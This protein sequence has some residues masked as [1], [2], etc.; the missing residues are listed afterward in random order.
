[1]KR[2]IAFLIGICM[3]ALISCVFCAC[4]L[5]FSKGVKKVALTS[6][7]IRCSL[8]DETTRFVYTGKPIELGQNYITVI[9]DGEFVSNEYFD[10][11]YENNVNVGVGTLRVTA[12]ENNPYAK[13]SAEIHFTI[14][15]DG[16]RNCDAE[17]DL[18]A[19]LA[20]PGITGVNLWCDKVVAEGETLTV[21]E[22]KTLSMLYGY[23]FRNEG[24][25]VNYGTIVIRGASLSTGGRR[26]SE[27]VNNGTFTNHGTLTLKD[28]AVVE[29]NGI[30][31]SDTE[32]VNLGTVYLKD[33]D[34]T[35][36]TDGQSGVHHVRTPVTADVFSVAECVYTQGYS[37]YTPRVT[38]LTYGTDFTV[39]Y[40]D[41]HHAG[42]A[43]AT[44]TMGAR[45]AR[46][47][48]SVDLPFV[49]KRGQAT[50][51]SLAQMKELVES[52]DYIRYTISALNIPEG[53]TFTLPAGETM[54]VTNGIELGGRMNALGDVTCSALTVAE[55]ATFVNGG[56]LS[57]SGNTFVVSG[58]FENASGG[59]WTFPSKSVEVSGT[60]INRGAATDKNFNI[61]GGTLRNE[62]TLGLSFASYYTGVFENVGNATFL[63]ANAYSP[64]FRNGQGGVVTLSGDVR[65]N[66]EF[67]NAGAVVNTGRVLLQKNCAYAC[68]GTF[69]NAEGDVWAY[70]DHLAGV[71]ENYHPKKELSDESVVFATQY[72]ETPYNTKDQKPTFTVDGEPLP[73]GE[74]SCTYYYVALGKYQTECIRTGEIRM[75]VS[76]KT[77]YS[78]YAGYIE[79]TYRII[80]A[81]VRVKD[82]SAFYTAAKDDGYNEI[83][84]DADIEL[85]LSSS[86]LSG[87]TLDLNEHRLKLRDYF[88]IHGTLTGGAAVDPDAFTPSAE[89]AAVIVEKDGKL[90]NY[91]S[92]VNDGFLYVAYGGSFSANAQSTSSGSRGTVVNNGVIYSPSD[93]TVASGAGK[94]YRRRDLSDLKNLLKVPTVAYDG[95]EKTPLPTMKYNGEDVDMERFTY[96]YDLNLCAGTALV[97]LDVED[98]FDPDFIGWAS[99]PF[100]IERGTI[101]VLN[102]SELAAAA[103][104]PNYETIRLGKNVEVESTIPFSDDQ[105]FDIGAYEATGA[106]KVVL[107][108]NCKLIL[109]TDSE[110]RFVKY[111]Y[112]A[113]EITLTG[114]IGVAGTRT[115][116]DFKG[117]TLGNYQNANYLSTTVHLD[118]YS[119]IG[120]LSIVNGSIENFACEFENA[121][122]TVS[123]I[124]SSVTGNANG[125]ALVYGTCYEE[126]YVTLRNITVYGVSH[127]GGGGT[128]QVVDLSAEKCTFLAARDRQNA[129]AFRVSAPMSGSGTYTECTFDG[130]NAYYVNR[131]DKYDHENSRYLPAYFFNDC[132][133][134]SYAEYDKKNYYGNAIT[135]NYSGNFG[136]GVQITNSQL[137]SEN[138]YGI[139]V[140]NRNNAVLLVLDNA[141]TYDGPLSKV[142]G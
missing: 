59:D 124:G 32:I 43:V 98:P 1:M 46:Y 5:I 6:E 56:D 122:E 9:V 45:D 66:T 16:S 84:L 41:N 142:F 51:T 80:P 133:L 29:D 48:G 57:V 15:A 63:G 131:G 78:S 139:Q 123:T 38:A 25:L 53:D 42:D 68:S 140:V 82:S 54:I 75:R 132:T 89:T 58:T 72:Y 108:K 11:T 141:T 26:A 104:D 73:T 52:G 81:S 60:F 44:V 62:G 13:G 19:L 12:K 85:W 87:C 115:D 2:R 24:T 91:G 125:Y 20:D 3:L 69:D 77:D 49:I 114:D 127:G 17:D 79:H 7:M 30:F 135:M 90:Y 105:L 37:E 111:F 116:L 14:V 113:D 8:I 128:S 100:T 61:R 47:Y 65:F 107:G 121:S 129:Y 36:L 64:A 110:A 27:L 130:A 21:P 10:F 95:T 18:A 96:R 138:G 120:G 101:T 86:V 35:F 88:F 39:G 97:R 23:R 136:L 22:G 106:G 28:Y 134:H 4:S 76:I 55:G 99:L 31:T 74:Y 119:F 94:V 92:I 40:T 103:A 117:Y 109:T 33:N 137:Y 83:V 34:K 71:T 112:A 126:T 93:V 50:A 102:E 118:G 67:T 70:A